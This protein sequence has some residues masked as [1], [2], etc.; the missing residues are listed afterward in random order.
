M[1]LLVG[2]VLASMTTRLVALDIGGVRAEADVAIRVDANEERRNVNHVLANRDV[3]LV[4]HA[5]SVVNRA[6]RTESENT[7]LE[8]TI[9][10]LLNVEGEE[11]IELGVSTVNDAVLSKT[12]KEGSTF[13]HTLGGLERK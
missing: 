12:T 8:T 11:S 10:E 2:L 6:S 13:V 3:A 7:G 9:K 1:H 4:D 5:T